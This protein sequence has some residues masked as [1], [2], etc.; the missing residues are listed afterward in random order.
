MKS[1]YFSNRPYPSQ[2]C[3]LP[4]PAGLREAE[5]GAAA[6]TRPGNKRKRTAGLAESGL[7]KRLVF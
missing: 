4:L 3:Q 5:V 6:A 1:E 2:G 7:A